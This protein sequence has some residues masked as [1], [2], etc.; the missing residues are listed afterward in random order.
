ML[1]LNRHVTWNYRNCQNSQDYR[2][3]CDHRTRRKRRLRLRL[4]MFIGLTPMPIVCL[5]LAA[6]LLP[7]V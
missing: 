2:T 7:S 4:R 5:F 1:F 3:Y 6:A